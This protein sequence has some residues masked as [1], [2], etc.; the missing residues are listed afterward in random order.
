MLTLLTLALAT[1]SPESIRFTDALERAAGSP[2]VAGAR[3]AA[4]EKA[5]LDAE[6]SRLTGNPEVTVQPGYRG[7]VPFSGPEFQAGISQSF[8]L[9]GLSSARREAAG[10]E[11]QALSAEAEAALLNRQL[12]T[13]RGWIDAWTAAARKESVKQEVALAQELRDRIALGA[14]RGAFTA[15]DVADADVYLA[16]A[17]IAVIDAEAMV[18]ES[19]LSLAGALA[20]TDGR[21]IMAEGPL[22]DLAPRTITA[23]E[24]VASVGNHPNV[25]ALLGAAAAERA[26]GREI[27]AAN[28]WALQLGVSGIRESDGSLIGFAGA[29]ATFPLF[30]RGQRELGRSAAEAAGLQGRAE[31]ARALLAAEL[32][33][34]HHEVQHTR[35]VLALIRDRLQPAAE[36]SVR[37][38]EKLLLAGEATLFEVLNA[39][40]SAAAVRARLSEAEGAYALA[41][42]RLALL[43]E[44][45][46]GRDGGE[47][48]K[49]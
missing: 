31:S 32:A 3:L 2:E 15:A 42:V 18:F 12:E 39:R 45:L 40:R 20:R 5:R 8:N 28:G 16:E 4:E 1:A 43:V 10:A 35:D 48:T 34:G 7:N 25:R 41:R 23:Q 26:R 19:G 27:S 29:G 38:K 36:E 9:S 44:T 46:L 21:P 17:R 13:A 47:E 11:L 14:E 24:L 37:L 6:I 30:E 22:P 33:R 49:Q